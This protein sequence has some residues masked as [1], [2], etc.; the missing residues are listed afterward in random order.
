MIY[1]SACWV[2]DL[3]SEPVDFINLIVAMQYYS[4]Y[5]PAY[6]LN[7]LMNICFYYDLCMWTLLR[8]N[9]AIVI[10]MYIISYMYYINYYLPAEH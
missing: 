6:S 10:I 7:S 5:I 3:D 2:Q 1:I 4:S 9:I 8:I